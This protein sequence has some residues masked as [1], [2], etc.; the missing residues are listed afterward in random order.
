MVK[1]NG[2]EIQ[3]YSTFWTNVK[4]AVVVESP[5]RFFTNNHLKI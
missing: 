1:N 3:D 5:D 2:S 4:K